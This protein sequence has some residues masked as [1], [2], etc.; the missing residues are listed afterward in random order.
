MRKLD[1]TRKIWLFI[2]TL[3]VV[4]APV[5]VGFIQAA[6]QT[7]PAKTGIEDTWQ[8]TLHLPGGKDLRT[9]IKV[10]GTGPAMKVT[11]YS[12]DQGGQPI[13]ASS[14]SFENGVFKY[15]ITFI[16]GS[17]EGK[18]SSDGK[19]ITGTWKQGPGTLSLV[20]ERA[21]PAT[22][23]AIPEPPP[24]IPPMA[25]TADPSFEVATIKPSKPDQPGKAL[26]LQGTSLVTVNTTAVDLIEFSYNV[27]IK[28]IVNAPSW[29]DTDKFDITAKPDTPG[30]PSVNQMKTMIQK[31][32]ADRFQ[33]KLHRDKKELSAYVLSVAKGGPK[34]QQGDPN[35]IPGLFFR[36]LGVLTVNNAS[37][38]DFT[39]LMQSAVLDRPIVDQT[40]LQGRW[41]FVLKWTPD[42]TQFSGMGVKVPP[43]SDAA[44]APPP[45]FTAIQEQI[46]LKLEAGKVPA[47]VL[48]LDHI[49]KPSEN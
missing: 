37:M 5:T 9:V 39:G 7:A 18:M 31:L 46:G 29:L 33:M 43:P 30:V 28:Q 13:P 21:T 35:A 49:E 23:W 32:L 8:G 6:A 38:E 3:L 17:Y 36:Q 26:T 45:L 44:D 2:A 1:I 40:G 48:V 12:I 41:I 16:D 42:E 10:V 15:A 22:E 20:Y 19:S 25:A 4:A 47:P 11:M 24:K 14:S 34:M 27:Q